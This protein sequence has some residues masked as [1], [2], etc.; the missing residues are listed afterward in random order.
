[1]VLWTQFA[2]ALV[3]LYRLSTYTDPQWNPEV[4][5]QTISLLEIV[6][7]VGLRVDQVA[8]AA[9]RAGERDYFWG[10]VAGLSQLIRAWLREQLVGDDSDESPGASAAAW[11][12][13][14]GVPV[15]G[16]LGIGGPG[17]GS[18]SAGQAES[19]SSQHSVAQ[20]LPSQWGMNSELV[21]SLAYGNEAWLQTLSS[22]NFGAQGHM[23]P[24][25]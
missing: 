2:R 4:V 3:N 15:G 24:P 20:S 6:E 10:R 16:G 5:T 11:V 14:G 19:S 13:A 23:P 22:V 9:A 8:E 12:G 21:D 7:S 1:M 17:S 18:G 25:P